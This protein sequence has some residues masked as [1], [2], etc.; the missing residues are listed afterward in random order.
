MRKT[1]SLA[2]A[3]IAALVVPGVSSAAP[4]NEVKW[5][6]CPADVAAPGVECGT[7]KVPLDHRKPE[8]RQTEVMISRLASKNPEK[9]RGILL[10]NPGGPSEGL[11]FPFLR[12]TLW[13]AIRR[14]LPR[15]AG[16]RRRIGARDAP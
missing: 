5:V 14:R 3:A 13:G 4:A 10:T 6:A 15:P 9:R 16:V 2:M 8:G 11:T 7:L 12:G 1:L